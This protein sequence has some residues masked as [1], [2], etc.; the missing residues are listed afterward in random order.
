M[1]RQQTFVVG[2]F[3]F[4]LGNGGMENGLVKLINSSDCNDIKH[5]IITL[6]EDIKL[7][8]RISESQKV[9]IHIIGRGS[10]FRNIVNLRKIIKEEHIEILHAR[11]WPTMIE[12][13][14]VKLFC[15]SLKNIFAFHGRA[16]T[17][18]NK[19]KMPRK[20]L[21]VVSAR[22]FNK[23]S[24]LTQF[25][26]S[27]ISKEFKLPSKK[28]TLIPNGVEV[29]TPISAQEYGA[30]KKS[31]GLEKNDF[32]IGYVGRLDPVKDIMTIIVAFN[33]F[34]QK[35]KTGY[36]VII[37]EGELGGQ[38]QS[39]SSQMACAKNIIFVGF[40]NDVA[41]LMQT[42]DIYTQASLYEG[43]SNTI[44]EAMACGLPVVC[45][46]SGGNVDVI[47]PGENGYLVELKDSKGLCQSYLKLYQNKNLRTAISTSNVEKIKKYYSL[48]HMAQLYM[49][50]YRSLKKQP[51]LLQ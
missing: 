16:Y 47:T 20:I 40:R 45:T 44:L 42:F 37:G 27:E 21:Q 6:T 41:Q 31:L 1:T 9:K 25:M 24:T 5:V 19:Q 38:L 49:T 11:G 4:S 7:M 13:A 15:P 12:G 32:V 28:I 51:S 18:L 23:I 17:E 14:L 26:Q 33:Q 48:E 10:I 35:A 43:L 22:L 2:H 8:S 36:L 29:P 34:Y 50:M 46:K 39:Q 30:Y 3:L